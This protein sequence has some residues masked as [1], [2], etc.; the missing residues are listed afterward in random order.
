MICLVSKPQGIV[1][2]PKKMTLETIYVVRH[3]YRISW[4]VDYKTGQY[5]ISGPV[6][7]GIPADPPLVAY[8]VEQSKQLAKHV[9]TLDPPVDAVLSSPWYRCLQTL[10]PSIEAMKAKGKDVKVPIDNGI[11]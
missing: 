5:R 8:G 6:P 11:A 9:M 4:S 1:L 2:R 10:A 3:G 7:T